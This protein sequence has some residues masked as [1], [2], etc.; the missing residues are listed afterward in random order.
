[1]AIFHYVTSRRVCLRISSTGVPIHFVV[2]GPLC[3]IIQ[4]V[5]VEYDFH[6]RR[7]V[8]NSTPKTKSLRPPT[9][10]PRLG[11]VS[12]QE[13]LTGLNLSVSTFLDTSG[14]SSGTGVQTLYP[15]SEPFSTTEGFQWVV[16]TISFP[17][18]RTMGPKEVLQGQGDDRCLGV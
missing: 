2:K 18:P 11:P 10:T 8:G 3:R 12:T 5:V 15:L 14:S 17:D 13:R 6:E 16:G 9:K 4:K 1:M 7:L